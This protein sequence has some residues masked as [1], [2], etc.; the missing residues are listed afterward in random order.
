MSKPENDLEDTV[1]RKAERRRRAREEGRHTVW[2]GVGM[3]GLVGWAVAVPTLAGVA[4][5]HW[6]DARFAGP[7]SWTITGL[8]AGVAIGCLNAWWWMQRAGRQDD[9]KGGGE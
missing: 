2:F 7:P 6:L 1:G 4:L 3:F 5:G 8:V 9:G